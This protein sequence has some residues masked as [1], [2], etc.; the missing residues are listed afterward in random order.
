MSASSNLLNRLERLLDL[1]EF[2]NLRTGV[3][4]MRLFQALWLR[5]N[6]L[7]SALETTNGEQG[8]SL[9]GLVFHVVTVA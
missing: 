6:S 7:N 3:R 2:P 8:R 4:L 1:R 9:F 5:P